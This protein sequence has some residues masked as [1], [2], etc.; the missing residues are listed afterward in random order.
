MSSLAPSLCDRRVRIA[1]VGCGRISHNHI[2]AQLHTTRA[3]LVAICDLS[4]IAL[5]RL[6]SAFER[7]RKSFPMKRPLQIA[8][9]AIRSSCRD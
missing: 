8:L 4:K 7:P 6:F 2:N 5:C 9:V 1:L 3:E